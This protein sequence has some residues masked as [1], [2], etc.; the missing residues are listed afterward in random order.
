MNE[1]IVR[2]VLLG[3]AEAVLA[4]CGVEINTE[5]GTLTHDPDNARVVSVNTLVNLARAVSAARRCGWAA[6]E[7]ALVLRSETRGVR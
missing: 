3:A 7:E 1:T 2:D 6:K 4:E 5:A